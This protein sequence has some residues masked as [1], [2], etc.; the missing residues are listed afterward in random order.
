[1]NFSA[2]Q[3]KEIRMAKS[4]RKRLMKSTLVVASILGLITILLLPSLVAALPL[5]AQHRFDRAWRLV[6]DFGHQEKV[7]NGTQSSSAPSSLFGSDPIRRAWQLAK[8]SGRY[9]YYADARQTLHP[10]ARIENG[11]RS[12]RTQRITAS[13]LLDLNNETMELRIWSQSDNRTV[14]MRLADGKTYGRLDEN[15]PWEEV[16]NTSEIFAPGGDP[17]GFLTAAENIQAVST[18]PD[19]NESGANSTD[20]LYLPFEP[21]PNAYSRYTFDINGT[22]YAQFMRR[23]MQEQMRRNGELPPGMSLGQAA[24]LTDITAHGELWLDDQG[25]PARQIIHMEFPAKRDASHWRTVEVTTDFSDWSLP[26]LSGAAALWQEPALVLQNPSAV[27]GISR[28]ALQQAG[29]AVGFLFVILSMLLTL[30]LYRHSRKLQLALGVTVAV[31]LV[32]GPLLQAERVHAFGV[33]FDERI[34]KSEVE[35]EMRESVLSF[36]NE[37]KVFNPSLNPLAASP[38]P[39]AHPSYL[40]TNANNSSKATLFTSAQQTT[41]D[42]TD[43]GGD[44]DGDG[45]SNGIE[46]LELGTDPELIDS[47]G[48]KISDG[49]EVAGFTLGENKWYLDPLHPDSNRDG[50]IDSLECPELRDVND[51][52]ALITPSGTACTNS[53]GDNTPDVFDFDNDGDGVPDTVD[54]NPYH[55]GELTAGTHNKL[56]LSVTNYVSEKPIL[57]DIQLRPTEPDHL[58]LT[59]NVFD[60]ADNDEQGQIQRVFDTTLIDFSN[61]EDPDPTLANGDM[62][63]TPMLEVVVPAPSTNSNPSGGLPIMDSVADDYDFAAVSID[64]WLDREALRVHGIEAKQSEAGA[65]IYLYV[66]LTVIED[67]TGDTPVAWG[68]RLLYQPMLDSWGSEHEV[69]LIWNVTGIVDSCDTDNQPSDVS[70][71]EWCADKSNWTSGTTALHVY[72]ED[73]SV[74]SLTATEEQ[75]TKTAIIAQNNAMDSAVAY[76]D[77]LWYLAYRLQQTFTAGNLY[78]DP[79]DNTNKRF[80]I[81]EIINRFDATSGVYGAGTDQLWGIDPTELS[82]MSGSAA[83]QTSAMETLISTQIPALLTNTYGA[84]AS[85]PVT[86]LFAREEAKRAISLGDA[87]SVVVTNGSN[88]AIDFDGVQN[89]VYTSLHW[90]AFEYDGAS[91][92]SYDLYNFLQ[93]LESE[94]TSVLTTPILTELSDGDPADDEE[95]SRLGAINLAKN[96]YLVLNRG[97][98]SIT[99]LLSSDGSTSQLFSDDVIVDSDLALN[100]Q[101]PMQ[102]VVSDLLQLISAVTASTSEVVIEPEGEAIV[103]TFTANLSQKATILSTV[104]AMEA[105]FDDSIETQVT[106]GIVGKGIN[107]AAQRHLPGLIVASVDLVG[108]YSDDAWDMGALLAFAAIGIELAG[109]ELGW[110]EESTFAVAT[111]LKF[112][113]AAFD[114]YALYNYVS[115]YKAAT[116]SEGA[117]AL[118]ATARSLNNANAVCAIIGFVITVAIAVGVLIYTM[119]SQDIKWGSLQGNFLVAQTIGTIIVAYIM[120]GLAILFPIGTIIVAIIAAIDL[121]ITTICTA[122]QHS[123]E[124]IDEDVNEWVCGGISSAAANGITY[125]IY[126]QYV[127]VDLDQDDRIQISLDTPTV[128]DS[129]FSTGGRIGLSMDLT[130]T[131][132]LAEPDRLIVRSSYLDANGKLDRNRLRDIMRRSSFDYSLQTRERT[133][134]ENPLSL[135]EMIWTNDRAVFARSANLPFDEPGINRS[136]GLV[137]TEF[138]NVAVIECW[139][140]I[141]ADESAT[142]DEEGQKQ[143]V[144]TDLSTFVFDIFPATFAE[145]ASLQRASNG[146]QRLA[147]GGVTAFPIQVDADGDGLRSRAFNG[148]DPNDEDADSDDDGL[149]D[150]YEVENGTNPLSVDTDDDGLQDYWEVFYR[151]NPRREDSDGDGLWDGAEFYHSGAPNPFVA[152]SSTWTGGWLFTY[153]F[154][155]SSQPMQMIV[156]ADPTLYDSDFDTILDNAEFVYSYNPNLTSELNVLSLDSGIQ[157]QSAIPGVAKQGSTFA[158]T[159]TVRNELNNRAMDGLLEIE[160]PVDTL[161]AQNIFSPLYPLRSVDLSGQVAVGSVGTNNLAIRAGIVADVETVDQAYSLRFDEAAGSTTFFDA[162]MAQHDFRCD[163]ATCPTATGG[164]LAF[165]AGDLITTAHSDAFNQDAFTLEMRLDTSDSSNIPLYRDLNDLVVKLDASRHV[166]IEFDG[167]QVLAGTISLIQNHVS[168]LLIT[169]NGV[170][171]ALYVDGELDTKATVNPIVRNDEAIQIGGGSLEL[172][173]VTLYNYAFTA[174]DVAELFGSLVFYANFDDESAAYQQSTWW[175]V[176]GGGHEHIVCLNYDE[177]SRGWPSA[178]ECDLEYQDNLLKDAPEHRAGEGISGSAPYFDQDGSWDNAVSNWPGSDSTIS[179]ARTD[180]AF[181]FSLWLKK[182]GFSSGGANGNRG[183]AWLEST[184]GDTLGLWNHTEFWDEEE[185]LGPDGDPITIQ[186]RSTLDSSALVVELGSCASEYN[187][188]QAEYWS[189]PGNRIEVEGMLPFYEWAHV[190]VT[191]DGSGTVSIYKNGQFVQSSSGCGSV[192]F[193]ELKRFTLGQYVNRN[194]GNFTENGHIGHLDEMRIYSKELTADEVDLLYTETQRTL[195]LNFDEPPGQSIFTDESPL[196]ANATCAGAT[197]PDGGLPGRNNQAL[198]FDGTD[199]YVALSTAKVLGLTGDFTVM[200]WVKSDANSSQTILGT[201]ASGDLQQLQLGLQNGNPY[202]S[203]GGSAYAVAETTNVATGEWVHLAFRFTSGNDET[204]PSQTIF[205]NGEEKVNQTVTASFQGTGTVNIGRSNSANYLNGMLDHLVIIK[206]ALT[207]D[208]IKDVMNE[209]P[210]FNLHLDEDLTVTSFANE[211]PFDSDATCL[212]DS[213]PAAGAKGVMREAPV[214]DGDDKLTLPTLTNFSDDVS[215]ALWVK[216]T[217]ATGARQYILGNSTSEVNN[218]YEF[219]LWIDEDGTTLGFTAPERTGSGSTAICFADD[220]L[221]GIPLKEDQWNHVMVTIDKE[222]ATSTTLYFYVNGAQANM[223]SF[224]DLCGTDLTAVGDGFVGHIDELAIYNTHLSGTEAKE[225]YNYQASW[226]DVVMYHQ[227]TVDGENPVLSL[228][229]PT[230]MANE[231]T[232]LHLSAVDNTAVSAVSFTITPPAGS[233]YTAVATANSADGNGSWSYNFTPSGAGNYNITA[234][235]T[236]VVGYT[237]T[238][239]HMLYVDD[240][241]PSATLDGSLTSGPMVPAADGV[242]QLFGTLSDTGTV[243]SGVNSESVSVKLLDRLGATVDGAQIATVT[244]D[245]DNGSAT[246]QVN[247]PLG[248]QAYGGY[249]VEVT[250]SDLA[251]NSTTTAVGTIQLDNL[252]PYADLSVNNGIISATNTILTGA[253]SDVPL[254]WQSNFLQMHFE[255]ASGAA[256]FIDSSTYHFVATCDSGAGTCPTAGVDGFHGNAVQFDGNDDLAVTAQ[257]RLTMTTGTLMAWVQPN[258]STD[259]TLLA[260]ADGTE[261]GFQW[262][263]QGNLQALLVNN[264]SSIGSIPVNLTNGQWTHLALSLDDDK[265]TAHVDGVTVG[266]F[267]QTVSIPADLPLHIGSANGSSGFFNGRLD[268]VMI[269]NNLLTAEQIY[270]IANLQATT[271]SELEMQIR[272]FN[273]GVWPDVRADGMRLYLPLDDEEDTSTYHVNSATDYRVTCDEAGGTCPTRTDRGRR[274]GAITLD[275]DD[276]ITISDESNFDFQE[277]SIS[278]WMKTNAATQSNEALITKGVDAWQITLDAPW[279]LAFDTPGVVSSSGGNSTQLSTALVDDRWHHVVAVYDGSRKSFYVNGELSGSQEVVGTMLTNDAPVLLGA[280]ADL[281][282]SADE[283]RFHG[284]LDEVVFFDRALSEAEINA[285][286][287]SAPWQAVA[288]DTPGSIYSTWQTALPSAMEGLYAISLRTTDSV[289]NI[290]TMSNIWQGTI[291]VVPPQASFIYETVGDSEVQVYCA[292]EDFFLDASK[293]ICPATTQTATTADDDWLLESFGSLAVIETLESDQEIVPTSGTTTMTAC[294]MARNCTTLTETSIEYSTILTPTSGTA[295]DSYDPITISGEAFSA[296]GVVRLF[297]YVNDEFVSSQQLN[298]EG[299]TT[300]ASWSI[301]WTPPA[302][303]PSFTLQA[304]VATEDWEGEPVR[305]SDDVIASAEVVLTAPVLSI[306]KTVAPSSLI[307]QGDNVTYTV[308][309]ANNT[310]ATNLMGV[311]ITD[312]LPDGV[313]GTDLATTVDLAV[314]EVIT[315]TIP[316][317]V[318]AATFESVENSA[319]AT[320]NGTSFS[321][322]ASFFSCA[323]SIVVQ[324]ASESGAGSLVQAISDLCEG[325]TIT[326]ASDLD[327][328][329]RDVTYIEKGMTIDGGDYDVTFSSLEDL[330][331]LQNTTSP[332]V[333]KNMNLSVEVSGEAPPALTALAGTDVTLVDVAVLG[334]ISTNGD[335]SIISSQIKT[336]N[337]PI[338]PLPA[339]AVGG[340]ST[341]TIV[342][343]TISGEEIGAPIIRSVA[344]GTVNAIHSTIVSSGDAILI[345]I[346][347]QNADA[348]ST[349]IF[350]NSIFVNENYGD[351]GPGCTGTGTYIDGGYNLFG[352]GQGCPSDSGTSQTVDASMLFSAV[353]DSLADNGGKT[354]T[355]ALFTG[356][357]AI[358]AIPDSING[359]GIAYA[360]DQR[361]VTRPQQDACDI[362]A[363]EFDGTSSNVAP[364]LDTIPMQ[365]VTQHATL[366]FTATASDA[367]SDTLRFS[368]D[369]A[370]VAATIDSH[371]GLFTWSTDSATAAGLYTATVIVSDGVLTDSQDVEIEVIENGE[372]AVL[373]YLPLDEV[374]GATTFTDVSGNGSDATCDA[375]VGQCPAAGQ[376]GINGTALTFDGI[377]DYLTVPF[378]LSPAERSFTAAAWFNVTSF[379]EDERILQQLDDEGVGR[380]WLY[381]TAGGRL[382]TFLGGSGISGPTSVTTDQWHHA[383]VSYDQ[384]SGL[385]SLYLDGQLEQRVSRTME[386]SLGTMRVGAH[387]A[388]SR[389]NGSIDEVIIYDTALSAADIA[390]MATPPVQA[391][392]DTYRADAVSLLN[393]AAPGV[394]ANDVESSGSPLTATLV[395]TPTNGSVTL[396]ADGSFSYIPTPFFEGIDS[397]TYQATNGTDSSS[398]T[399]VTISVTLTSQVLYLPLDE[400]VGATNFGDLSGNGSDATCESAAGQ[401]PI[402]GEVSPFTT[403]LRFDGTDDYLTAPAIIDPAMGGFTAALWFRMPNSGTQN[404]ILLAQANGSGSGRTWFGVQPDGLFYSNLGNVTTYGEPTTIEPSQWYH[405]ALTYDGE[406]SRLRLFLNGTQVAQEQLDIEG[407]DGQLLLGVNK[408]LRR[409]YTGIIDE[410]RIF[411]HVVTDEAIVVLATFPDDDGDGIADGLEAGAANNGDGNSDGVADIEQENVASLPVAGNS[412]GR[413]VTLAAPQGNRLTAV[414]V[415]TAPQSVDDS[416]PVGINL[417]IGYV[418]FNVENVVVGGSLAIEIFPPDASAFTTYYKY[419]SVVAGE[420]EQWYEFLYDGTTGAEILADR[421]IL[422]LVDGGRGDADLTA[423]GVITDPGLPGTVDVTSVLHSVSEAVDFNIPFASFDANGY[424][425]TWIWGDGTRSPATYDAASES[426]TDS[427]TY[428]TAGTYQTELVI[429]A[430]ANERQRFS[431]AFDVVIYDPDAG[432]TAGGGKIKSPAGA[433]QLDESITGLV[434]FNLLTRYP[435]KQAAPKGNFRFDFR[436]ANLKFEAESYEWLIVNPDGTAM[437]RGAGMI[438]GEMDANGNLYQFQLWATDGETDTLRVRIWAEDSRPYLWWLDTGGVVIYDNGS[439]LPINNGNVKVIVSNGGG[440]RDGNGKGNGQALQVEEQSSDHQI[441]L[442]LITS[443][444]IL[445][446]QATEVSGNVIDTG[447]SGETDS[448]HESATSG[449]SNV[450]DTAEHLPLQI[451]LPLVYSVD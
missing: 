157:T 320:Y 26:A 23:Q 143:T 269:Y 169:Y 29:S 304:Y 244:S 132:T 21:N 360:T 60:W 215:M 397:F 431:E 253:V 355:H 283:R 358:N 350:T 291:D 421:I 248:P 292:A 94:L 121:I 145:F 420:P 297:L 73:F 271:V 120:T 251:G 265:W 91:W 399:K 61:S 25:L 401:C 48:D 377:D 224:Q 443:N 321:A 445:T 359:C 80:D 6:Q 10:T 319:T 256:T 268:E 100:H 117:S 69:R 19:S 3:T 331:V 272:H 7:T 426:F 18:H 259:G 58:W 161:Q 114:S 211:G 315:Y 74:T 160:Y 15:D 50:Q 325:G 437:A 88:V 89:L 152:D 85:K 378:V 295:L 329:T 424:T 56:D 433:Y 340:N 241:A 450:T 396:N 332:I 191:Y 334:S 308:V 219:R 346:N 416:S 105:S 403:A 217:K 434:K 364:V 402:A 349:L 372:G 82:V 81:D 447:E 185:I 344:G 102:L 44:C 307:S 84:D 383:A 280:N 33:D 261:T 155:D 336:V 309:V 276:Y 137:L 316:A 354:Q 376:S 296:R 76:A 179:M 311:I 112:A 86:L 381:V 59:N 4:T 53:D 202:F 255:E 9:E 288:L 13:G 351:G 353:L 31:A 301:V 11:G 299:S 266:T 34:A 442:P 162:T 24:S 410:V 41:C 231:T 43:S 242:Q 324:N 395:T 422:H 386:S 366:T 213:C 46:L 75:G 322:S 425:A 250:V 238:K 128:S 30:W 429:A 330:L 348:V 126:D 328:S 323:E 52:G 405:A 47:D 243:V 451:Y 27:F 414:S 382:A 389:F 64:Q 284:S 193:Q 66:P 147:W 385:L 357:P 207:G 16:D 440:T 432:K 175:D 228:D 129:G 387:K 390:S 172:D 101:N 176:Q 275:G 245:G 412:D 232:M 171:L 118:S 182:G 180:N 204:E 109:A 342:N 124:E 38:L 260:M 158:Y 371:S 347:A 187:A 444:A 327:I 188:E 367:D 374:V 119:T 199:D 448:V 163:A 133:E 337:L 135:D 428:S 72:Y 352:T 183:I 317:L 236:D 123:G 252:G 218:K 233:A 312:T 107:R 343:S 14:E 36:E 70:Y 373:L 209:A 356:S 165:G 300:N 104:G 290:R 361:G 203:F 153:D 287:T 262:Q 12:S 125:L 40:V 223:V 20:V 164:T 220:T 221:S 195:D 116:V 310:A 127:T 98:S 57:I 78:T 108:D 103:S 184:T 205:V 2:D 430:I 189:L 246:W 249:A 225:L 177:I 339:I 418:S 239:S 37:E 368:L 438:N 181:S 289:G 375:V 254:P 210:V 106:S 197:C 138:L 264:G 146:G 406:A 258:L 35:R 54:A 167:S 370:P 17:L 227:L 148:P 274:D 409:F 206:D 67:D 79:V 113:G 439:E 8:Q 144:N 392:V 90:G 270:N 363:Y 168:H 196:Q 441:F 99:E 318:T 391:V 22:K 77:R 222:S 282:G 154:D 201:D 93:H 313:D 423:N 115:F 298:D 166:N 97:L 362:G 380:T 306:D 96:F 110:D 95:L 71:D 130:N 39:A 134:D 417:P 192:D 200:A 136:S 413:Y 285:L 131:V 214:F 446:T 212:G 436:D 394:L 62:M 63:A 1:M 247:Y 393:V 279:Q 5:T 28:V 55:T 305:N 345:D 281:L 51:A 257:D 49:R 111:T 263:I 427:H 335:L 278:F 190:V 408:A 42:L 216:P 45:L 341:V 294:D 92:L 230:Y 338:T 384:E 235:A 151:T 273:G 326:F 226:F 411:D 140:F 32:V 149:S 178:I 139:G 302:G 286:R 141:G 404:R 142:C 369:N 240:T 234:V 173:E 333:I 208:E 170:E 365:S 388:A 68:A 83:D 267:T 194:T 449:E 198:R 400:D 303:I 398:W 159:A 435:K 174:D 293:W 314:G 419:G 379:T 122:L 156:S 150:F 407:N 186:I 237:D 277:M 65:P 87:T 229:L 415:T